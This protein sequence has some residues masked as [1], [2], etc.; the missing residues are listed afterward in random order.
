MSVKRI[1]YSD[2]GDKIGKSQIMFVE[3]GRILCRAEEE[4]QLSVLPGIHTTLCQLQ[5]LPVLKA[6]IEKD[7]FWDVFK[8]VPI[9][10]Q[11]LHQF[12]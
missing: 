12:T 1:G 5:Q 8:E 6:Q 4:L 2:I 10:Q 7:L 11:V 9:S 3:K